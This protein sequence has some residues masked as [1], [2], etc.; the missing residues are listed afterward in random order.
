[1]SRAKTP[2]LKLELGVIFRSLKIALGRKRVL[3]RYNKVVIVAFG[4]LTGQ[5]TMAYSDACE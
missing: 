1:M 2:V 3:S 4:V 5:A